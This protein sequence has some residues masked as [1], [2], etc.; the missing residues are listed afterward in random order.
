MATKRTTTPLPDVNI[1]VADGKRGWEIRSVT[2]IAV[3][4]AWAATPCVTEPQHYTVTCLETGMGVGFWPDKPAAA[5]RAVAELAAHVSEETWRPLARVL[6]NNGSLNPADQRLVRSVNQ[7]AKSFDKR[8]KAT[9][10][11]HE[12]DGEFV[13][14][15]TGERVGVKPGTRARSHVEM[16]AAQIAKRCPLLLE[17]LVEEG[18]AHR[19]PLW[20]ALRRRLLGVRARRFLETGTMPFTASYD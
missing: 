2:P 16:T 13:S 9:V 8:L 18:D 1:R 19:Y 12:Q 10:F 7:L 5:K 4:G 15:R 6:F 14:N 3:V 20:Y 11:V 17:Q